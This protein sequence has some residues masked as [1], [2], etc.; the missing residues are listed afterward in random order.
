MSIAAAEEPPSLGH[1]RP[2]AGE[3]LDDTELVLLV[4]QYMG[5]GALREALDLCQR[6]RPGAAERGLRLC[7]A[8]AHMALGDGAAALG[9]INELLEEQPADSLVS[10][11][12]AQFLA[13]SGQRDA[14]TEALHALLEDAPDFPGALPALAQLAFP[15]P[16]YRD[17]LRLLHQRLRPR[18]Y[19]EI[20]VESGA[21]LQLAHQSEL[22]LGVDPAPRPHPQR[23]PPQ[24]RLF[25]MTSDAFFVEHSRSSLLGER[26]VDLA[27]IDGMHLFEFALRDFHN[28]ERW[29]ARGSTV[30][31]HDCLPV[32][33]IAALRQR[34]T[35][36]WVGDTWKALEYLLGARPDLSISVVP[37]YPSGLVIIRN[38]SPD[39]QADPASLAAFER[40]YLDAPYPHRAGAWPSTYPF[41]AN[42]ERELERVLALDTTPTQTNDASGDG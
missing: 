5:V 24:A 8:R 9:I 15:G 20:G 38:L 11:Y 28:V 3:P 4:Q 32:A 37:C 25:G 2:I 17:V 12:Q 40:S 42:S 31:L 6:R 36:F 16:P 39:R 23:V 1:A 21:S 14:A 19:L 35:T 41:I 7:Q 30:V 26:R 29:C 10:F 13:Q 22:I 18:T 34:R 33:A 27:F